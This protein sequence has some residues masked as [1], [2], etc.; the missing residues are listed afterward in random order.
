MMRHAIFFLADLLAV[1][2]F[3]ST[4]G[5]TKFQWLVVVS[6]IRFVNPKI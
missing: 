1:L 5:L 2:F 4:Q 3:C 6:V